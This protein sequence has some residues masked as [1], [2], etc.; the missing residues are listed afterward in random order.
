MSIRL[1]GKHLLLVNIHFFEYKNK[2]K[3][4]NKSL[5]GLLK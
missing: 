1:E 3:Q 5:F 2:T 4:T